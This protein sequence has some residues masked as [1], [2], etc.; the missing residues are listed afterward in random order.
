MQLVLLI[1]AILLFLLAAL[2]ITLGPFVPLELA[3]LGLACFAG[4]HLP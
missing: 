1:G 3:Y 4:A 2:S